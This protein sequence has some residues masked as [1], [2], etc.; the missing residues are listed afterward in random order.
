MPIAATT[1]IV[2]AEV[3]PVTIPCDCMIVP[4]PR[5][6]TPETICAAMRAGIADARARPQADARGDV[7]QQR[8]ADADEDVRAQARRLAGDLALEPDD[9]AEEH[10]EGEL[11]EEVDAQHARDLHQQRNIDLLQRGRKWRAPARRHVIG[12]RGRAGRRRVVSGDA[13]AVRHAAG[14]GLE[15]VDDRF[16]GLGGGIE[17]PE[18]GAAAL[19]AGRPPPALPE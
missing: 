9:A 5:K 8:G 12:R 10:G 14:L 6:P 19:I 13:V 16:V 7:H 4:A 15:R 1:Q 11:D 2:A 3:S 17:G 18:D